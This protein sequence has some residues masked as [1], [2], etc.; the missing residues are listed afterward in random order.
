MSEPRRIERVDGDV[1][2]VS[3]GLTVAMALMMNHS[4]K[5]TA[6]TW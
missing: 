4:V 3:W 6:V 1:G 2:R 5:H